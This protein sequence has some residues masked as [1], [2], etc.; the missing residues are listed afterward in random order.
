MNALVDPVRTLVPVLIKW[1]GTDVTVQYNTP[2]HTVKPVS[3]QFNYLEFSSQ[4]YN[5]VNWDNSMI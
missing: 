3:V 1:T 4:N 2:V 5:K